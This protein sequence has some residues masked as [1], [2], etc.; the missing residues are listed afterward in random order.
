MRKPS[1][2]KSQITRIGGG[3]FEKFSSLDSA[4][5]AIR[6]GAY[7][8]PHGITVRH[9]I[10]DIGGVHTELRGGVAAFQDEDCG[11]AQAL[12]ARAQPHEVI[13][14]ER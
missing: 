12:Q 9:L 8:A 4:V 14:R 6:A 2:R 1:H 11:Q 5:G 13:A 3:R 7:E 10:E